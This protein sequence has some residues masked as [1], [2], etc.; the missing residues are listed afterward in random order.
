MDWTRVSIVVASITAFWVGMISIIPERYH[1]IGMVILSSLTSAITLMMRSGKSRIEK[2][3]DK[4]DEIHNLALNDV[5][6]AFEEEVEKV[7]P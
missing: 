2:I 5:K 6:D 4:V 7:K 1:H 3:D